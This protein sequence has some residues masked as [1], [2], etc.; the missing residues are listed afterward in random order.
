MGF[1]KPSYLCIAEPFYGIYFTNTVKVAIFVY[2]INIYH[3][4]WVGGK[5]GKF[6]SGY[7][8]FTAQGPNNKQKYDVIF[9]KHGEKYYDES[10]FETHGTQADLLEHGNWYNHLGKQWTINWKLWRLLPHILCWVTAVTRGFLYNICYHMHV[11]GHAYAV[12][13]RE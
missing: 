12:Q 2:V 9:D 8:A 5:I 11:H 6:F 3:A 1:T 10:Y 13:C 7:T 4:I